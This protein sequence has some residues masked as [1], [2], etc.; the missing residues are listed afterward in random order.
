[1][2]GYYD[3]SFRSAGGSQIYI[4]LLTLSSLDAS[5][6]Q[7]TISRIQRFADSSSSRQAIAFLLSEDSFVT[8]SGKYPLDGLLNLQVMYGIHYCKL[9]QFTQTRLTSTVV[10]RISESLTVPIPIVPIPDISCFSSSIQGYLNGIVDLPLPNSSLADSI[11]LLSHTTAFISLQ[12]LLEHDT[13]VLSDLFP[14][15]RAL[16]QAICSHEGQATVREY[17]GDEVALGVVRFWDR[18]RRFG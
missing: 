7:E 11:S 1:M 9:C 5:N 8:A 12:P 13:N 6:K 15:M 10:F 18:D 17:L 4:L 16:S 2:P 14:S 3:F